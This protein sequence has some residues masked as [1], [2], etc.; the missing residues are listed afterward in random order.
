M[1][2]ERDSARGEQARRLL[3]D[4]LLIEAFEAVEGNLR[5]AWIA[6]GEGQDR[7]RERL[8]LMVKLLGRL[9]AHLT[10]VLE[11]GKLADRQLAAL[12]ERQTTRGD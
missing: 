10:G 12:E 3:S 9:K 1:N 5:A 7:E 4:P 6:T 8:W 11:T 2:L